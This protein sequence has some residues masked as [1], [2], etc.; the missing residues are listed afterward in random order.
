MKKALW[1]FA[2]AGIML[3]EGVA[4]SSQ[5]KAEL[6]MPGGRSWKGT[7]V[8]RDGDW[9]EFSTGRSARPI[10]MGINTIEEL[11]F[12]VEVDA[13]KLAEMKKNRE[14]DRI[15]ASLERTLKPFAE[16]S[17][18]PSNLTKY[19]TLLMELHYKVRAY[20]KSLAISS[21]IAEDDRDPVLQEKARI[22]QALALIDGGQSDAAEA[23]L[24]KY[25][26]DKDVSDEAPPEKLYIT[27][28]LMVLKE[29]YN[30]AMELVAKVIAFN[31]QDPD[32]M[33]PSELLCAEV[34]TEL[35]MYDSAEEVCREIGIFYKDSV[36]SDKAMELKEKIERLRAE[37][38]LEQDLE[39]EEA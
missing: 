33:Q 23:L 29:Q 19:N 22:Y 16:F 9:L 5:I 4:Q 32:W 7:I 6:I 24:S 3:A 31:S 17:D 39:S 21:K 13:E 28:K 8:G 37:R 11:N 30:R 38:E 10:R 15:I 18:V 25:G 20:D 27:A 1:V 14:F 35:G 12:D 34:Y 26:W 36:E 2:L